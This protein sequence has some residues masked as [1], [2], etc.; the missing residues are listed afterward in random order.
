ML[1]GIY[2]EYL[3]NDGTDK[4]FVCLHFLYSICLHFLYISCLFNFLKGLYVLEEKK[5][6]VPVL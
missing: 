1:D 6:W 4:R 5:Q 3:Y 2:W